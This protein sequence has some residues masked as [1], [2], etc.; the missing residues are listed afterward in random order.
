MR[1][2]RTFSAVATS[3]GAI[4]REVSAVA[5]SAGLA[6]EVVADVA[7]AASEAATN[8]I[9]HGY[10]GADGTIH[11]CARVDGQEL[12][13]VVSDEGTGPVP[14]RDSPGLGLGLPIIASVAKC[15]EVG[16]TAGGGTR[17]HMVFDCPRAEVAG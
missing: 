14:R 1:L 3:V 17:V 9:V 6:D 4:R 11:V 16:T 13:L 15:V 2:E 10:R 5:R 7:L 12:V 8:A